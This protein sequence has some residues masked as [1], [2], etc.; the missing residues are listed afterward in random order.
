LKPIRE[1][2]VLIAVTVATVQETPLMN[3]F[4]LCGWKNFTVRNVLKTT[5]L[6]IDGAKECQKEV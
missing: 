5:V 4:G 6:L 2:L 1:S 3:R